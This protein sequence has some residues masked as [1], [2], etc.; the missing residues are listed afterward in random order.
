MKMPKKIMTYCPYCKK[1]TSHS[2]ERVRKRKASELK[3]GQRRFRRVTSGY[4]GFPRPKFEGREKP[5]K[6]IALRLVCD[7][8]HKAITP[9]GIRAKKFEIVEA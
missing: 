8:C 1:H 4:G 3:A 2:V 9:P 7:E 6:R 5:T